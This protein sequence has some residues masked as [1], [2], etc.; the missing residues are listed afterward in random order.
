MS[1]EEIESEALRLDPKA[2]AHL[3]ERLLESLE[4]L[5]E[6]EN[7]KLWA[8]EAERRDKS[9][10]TGKATARSAADAV[11]EARNKLG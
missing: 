3:A 6:E 5:S 1:I 7:D 4:S 10:N 8:E 11:R 2:R 9:W